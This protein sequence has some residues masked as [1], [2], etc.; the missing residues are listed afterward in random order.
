MTGRGGSGGLVAPGV[1]SVELLV[2][3][4]LLE[5]P[6]ENG[7]LMSRAEIHTS[8]ARRT[9]QLTRAPKDID[10]IVAS[11]TRSANPNRRCSMP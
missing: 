7:R 6:T 2:F 11:N 10:L 3:E 4:A 5:H 1:T 8:E 9:T